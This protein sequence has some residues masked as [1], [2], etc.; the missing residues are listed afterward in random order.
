MWKTCAKEIIEAKCASIYESSVHFRDRHTGGKTF[1]DILKIGKGM[2]CVPHLERN[3]RQHKG[4]Q[5]DK[6]LEKNFSTNALFHLQASPT[7]A[8][9]KDRLNSFAKRY[10]NTAKYI[11]AID[12]YK[13]VYYAQVKYMFY[14]LLCC[15]VMH[16]NYY[17]KIAFLCF[18]NI[19]KFHVIS[20]C[21]KV[22]IRAATFG[23][24]SNN[25]SEIGQ[26]RY[27]QE[28]RKCH[29]LDFISSV[30]RK[31][32]V[33]ITD[34]SNRH[35]I[36]RQQDHLNATNNL[37]PHGV[38]LFLQR[39]SDAAKCKVT[40]MGNGGLVVYFVPGS[41]VTQLERTVDIVGKT[42]TCGMWQVYQ[43]PCPC[44]IAVA[45]KQGLSASAFVEQNCGASYYI[46][47]EEMRAITMALKTCAAPSGEDLLRPENVDEDLCF[48]PPPSR[49]KEKHAGNKRKRK[50]TK[51]TSNS[52]GRTHTASYT[53]ASNHTAFK[54]RARQMCSKCV[55]AG[56]VVTEA[57][58]HKAKHCPLNV[59]D[60]KTD[61]N[62]PPLTRLRNRPKTSYKKG[63]PVKEKKP[64][65]LK[66]NRGDG[67]P[68]FVME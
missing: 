38:K 54:K 10:P 40:N 63:V 13:W 12:P 9:F 60:T 62:M 28:Y 48:I 45:L 2:Y 50:E 49:V 20:M 58:W 30:V 65:I 39:S 35:T 59:A 36:W 4:K 17:N 15:P 31:T 47:D 34:M 42:C 29:P 23:W 46:K 43:F 32:Y 8:D 16:A 61:L 41:G 11:E 21:T 66:A 52:S 5:S 64:R 25:M 37:V 14:I 33:I 27:L 51:S 24:R 53:S 6:V 26:G 57:N 18:R 67:L 3:I 19:A 55:R 22:E 44:A 1:E 7:S 68:T 56:V